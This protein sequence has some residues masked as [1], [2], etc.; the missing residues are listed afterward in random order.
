MNTTYYIAYFLHFYAICAS[1]FFD[2][3][4]NVYLYQKHVNNCW[5]PFFYADL[6][7]FR[8]CCWNK[9]NIMHAQSMFG[10]QVPEIIV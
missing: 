4:K 1:I 7:S 8:K 5:W 9:Q 2:R 3:Q 10:K 6:F